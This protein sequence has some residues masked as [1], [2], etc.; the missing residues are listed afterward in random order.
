M[1]SAQK[2]TRFI[3]TLIILGLFSN[4]VV[5]HTSNEAT[6]FPDI[7]DSE[8]KFDVILL[9]GIGVIPETGQ[10]NPDKKL[11][12]IELAAWAA[13]AN[14]LVVPEPGQAPD[15]K[16]L[17]LTAAEKGLIDHLTGH[18]NYKAINQVLFNGA[19]K[20]DN[21]LVNPTRAEA[22]EFIVANL[23]ADLSGGTLLSRLEMEMGPTGEVTNVEMKMNPDGGETAYLTIGDETFAVY[24]HGKVANGPVDLKQ[25]KEKN[26]RRSVV[27]NLGQFKLWV[28]LEAGEA[29]HDHSAHSH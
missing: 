28:F 9:V 3:S 25:W 4:T 7:Q 21:P 14:G 6:L 8:A 10:F 11:S 12:R 22:A 29:E 16:G 17:A 13:L 1:S 15:I 18:A 20:V 5:A 23:D 24:S 26:V 19:L 2:I 27:K